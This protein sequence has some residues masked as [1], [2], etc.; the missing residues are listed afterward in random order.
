MLGEENSTANTL[1]RGVD[2]SAGRLLAREAGGVLTDDLLSLASLVTSVPS[3]AGDLV[4][5]LGARSRRR[6]GAGIPNLTQ[7]LRG[8]SFPAV[9]VRM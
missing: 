3:F 4:Q 5:W 7:D 9:M 8:E 2:G 6:L 1:I